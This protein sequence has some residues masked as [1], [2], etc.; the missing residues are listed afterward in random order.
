MQF[1]WQGNRHTGR[2]QFR[3]DD[4]DVRRTPLDASYVHVCTLWLSRRVV[5]VT[6]VGYVKAEAVQVVQMLL[7]KYPQWRTEVLPSLQR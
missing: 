4:D 6:Q 2:Y 7:R 3:V 1:N 5:L